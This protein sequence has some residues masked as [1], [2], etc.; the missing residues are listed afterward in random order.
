MKS[1]IFIATIVFVVVL[2]Y[3]EESVK[4]TKRVG[5]VSE[6][7]HGSYGPYGGEYERHEEEII[8]GHGHGSGYHHGGG[9]GHGGHHG[10]HGSGIRD[11]DRYHGDRY[12]PGY[13][14][15]YGERYPL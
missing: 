3:S 10:G 4:D 2:V 6:Y 9:Y 12:E 13:R 5:V 1:I 15:G 7:E 14:P 11:H 8:A